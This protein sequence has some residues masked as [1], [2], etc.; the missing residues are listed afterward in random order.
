MPQKAC[1]N[2]AL[3]A[4]QTGIQMRGPRVAPESHPNDNQEALR[5]IYPRL[6]VN[7]V[8]IKPTLD[9]IA[10]SIRTMA[11]LPTD[12]NGPNLSAKGRVKKEPNEGLTQLYQTMIGRSHWL[13]CM[14]E[15]WRSENFTAE[16]LISG[17]LAGF[18]YRNLFLKLVPWHTPSC[19]LADKI[20]DRKH[21]KRSLKK[22][23]KWSEKKSRM[24]ILCVSEERRAPMLTTSK[25]ST[26][27]RHCAKLILTSLKT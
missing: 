7:Q 2:G 6:G 20:F 25:G 26:W 23:A 18:I 21:L 16:R 5:L 14:L 22:V 4:Q 17:L 1:L 8:E 3:A 24:L 11:E 27:T 10:K 12:A 19:M 13:D 15:P 9:S